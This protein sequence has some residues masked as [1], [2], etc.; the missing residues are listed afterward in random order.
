MARWRV[1]SINF[2]NSKKMKVISTSNSP[3]P[4][5]KTNPTW[6]NEANKKKNTYQLTITSNSAPDSDNPDTSAMV[7]SNETGEL[8]VFVFT[9]NSLKTKHQGRVA[10]LLMK[11]IG[12]KND[13]L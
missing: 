5:T 8:E 7:L 4:Q 1:M 10:N 6:P 12:N 2:N 11:L 13:N 9:K 3:S